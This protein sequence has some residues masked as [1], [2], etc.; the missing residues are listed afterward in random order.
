MFCML[1]LLNPDSFVARYNADRYLAGTLRNFDVEI[2][3]RS[4]PAGVD[5]ALKVYDKTDDQVL[6]GKLRE[7]LL[8]QRQQAAGLAGKPG[9]SL[10]RAHARDRITEYFN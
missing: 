5:S 7:Y 9:D 6:Q 2:L 8:I 4:G 10:Q 3:Y 1:C